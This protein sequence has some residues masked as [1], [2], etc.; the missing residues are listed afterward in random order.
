[1]Y[2]Y[3]AKIWIIEHNFY[4]SDAKDMSL[5]THIW[6][7][8]KI[9]SMEHNHQVRKF[10]LVW[11]YLFPKVEL[12]WKSRKEVMGNYPQNTRPNQKHQTEDTKSKV[13]NSFINNGN[14][15]WQREEENAEV[16]WT[17]SQNGRRQT[18][19]GNISS[20]LEKQQNMQEIRIKI[21]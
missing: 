5:E 11:R 7:L 13:T 3:E 8:L 20:Q 14:T 17:L 19:E 10:A 18:M 1:M 2:T 9:I 16:I 4:T 15:F 6:K 12:I 21:R